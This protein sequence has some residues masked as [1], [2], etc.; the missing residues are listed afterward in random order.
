[1]AHEDEQRPTTYPEAHPPTDVASEAEAHVV[2][3]DPD[4]AGTSTGT[5]PV[6]DVSGRRIDSD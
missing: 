1:M 6:E 4:Q 3:D 2:G 5:P